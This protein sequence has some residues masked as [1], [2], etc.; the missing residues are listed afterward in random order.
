LLGECD[1]WG[2]IVLA[3]HVLVHE[4]MHL[5]GIVDEDVAECLAVQMDALV[6]RRLGAAPT[7]ARSIASEYWRYYYASQDPRYRSADCQ[8]GGTY[9]A[10]GSDAWPTPRTYPSSIARSIARFVQPAVRPA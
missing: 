2:Q 4:S 5:A 6:V 7:F 3:L 8:N 1:D 9:D 10:F